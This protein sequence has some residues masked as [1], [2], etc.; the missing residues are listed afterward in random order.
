MMA[1]RNLR[2][3]SLSI[4]L[5]RLVH[6]D[7][8]SELQELELEDQLE[9]L[10]RDDE[11][12][13]QPAAEKFASLHGGLTFVGIK[14]IDCE[15]HGGLSSKTPDYFSADKFVTISWKGH[16]NDS[17]PQPIDVQALIEKHLVNIDL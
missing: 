17:I 12:Y 9:F 1:C 2:S 11:R 5:K 13:L 15:I 14:A 10:E 7:D 3:L 6:L 8:F 4:P 16:R